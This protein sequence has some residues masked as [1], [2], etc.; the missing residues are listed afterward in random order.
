MTQVTVDSVLAV[1]ARLAV[2]ADEVFAVLD[3][4]GALRDIPA[5]ADD[6]VSRDARDAF[7]RKIDAIL[8]KHWAYHRELGEAVSRLREAAR[9]YG[10]TDDA[11]LDALAR[12]RS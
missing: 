9:E 3:R 8:D 6:P 1:H 5:A 4:A 7:Q 12:A 11:V 10:H 2:R